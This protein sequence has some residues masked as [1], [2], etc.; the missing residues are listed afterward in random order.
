MNRVNILEQHDE[1]E[2]LL[3][4]IAMSLEEEEEQGLQLGESRYLPIFMKK[5]NELNCYDNFS[6]F[7]DT[8]EVEGAHLVASEGNVKDARVADDDNEEEL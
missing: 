1:D 3:R 4:A 8:D 5:I 2:M 7:S 6:K